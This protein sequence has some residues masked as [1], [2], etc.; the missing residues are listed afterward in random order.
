MMRRLHGATAVALLAALALAGCGPTQIGPDAEAFKAV[1]A[2]YTAISLREPERVDSC[3]ETLRSLHK[4][5]R[6]DEAAFEELS[7]MSDEA[8]GGE[9]EPVQS[10]LASFMR[11]QRRGR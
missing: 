9:W 5:G 6:L 4:D 3:V 10:R 2:L 1:D 7:K 8:K 11:G